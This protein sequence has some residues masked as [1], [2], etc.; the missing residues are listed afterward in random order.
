[1]KK[2]IIFPLIALALS[3]VLS[4]PDT[5]AQK[6][7]SA[8]VLLGA[9]L[10]QE[11]VEGNLEAA[12]ETYK[13]LLAEFPGNR[14]L[15]AQAQLHLGF[16]YEKLG[17]AQAKEARTAYERVVR[18]YADQAETVAQA[19]AR[20][21]ALA[22]L[23]RGAGSV[24][25]VTVR[26]AWAGPWYGG[27]G[28]PSRD[29]AYLTFRNESEDL[30]IRDLATGEIRQLTKHQNVQ[31]SAYQSVPSPDGKQVAYSWYEDG[32]WELRVVGLDGTAP[33]VLYSNTEVNAY[34]TDWSP[35]GKSILTVLDRKDRAH[36]IALVSSRDASVHPLKSS[37]ER[38]LARPRFS[39]D[40]RYIAYALQQ[41]PKSGEYDIFVLALEGGREIP[42][43]QHPAND[44]HPDWTPDGKRI[45]FF[46]NRTGT[47][48]AWWI[49]IAEGHPQGTPELVKPDLGLDLSPMGF[50]RNGSYYYGVH[51]EM[52]D[53]YIAELDLATGKLV[54]APS[55][56][57]QRFVGSNSKPDWSPDGL[58]LLFL[59]KRGAGY[60]GARAF[61]VRSTESGEVRELA[62]KLDR[63]PLA[64][65]LPDAR[66]L[67]VVASHPTDG[68]GPFRIDVQ[69]GDFV[70][71]PRP[72]GSFG[73]L[74][75]VSHDG[76]A[77]IYQGESTEPKKYC[78]MVRNLETS[79]N[80]EL[81]CFSD[82][83][84]FASRLTLSP[85]GSQLAFVM[86]ADTEGSMV[87]KVMPAAGGEARDLL[88]G[89]RI[90]FCEAP[91]AWAPDG[92]N[93]LFARQPNPPD[94]KTELWLISVQGGEPRRLE[95]A[96]EGMSDVCIHPDGRHIAFTEVKNRDEVWVLE[97]FL[98]APKAAK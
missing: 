49:Q 74:P 4:P 15:A 69:T 5:A 75:A 34:P 46:S 56:A 59:S 68:I 80:K 72:P 48:G 57:T 19:R 77:W 41:G 88:R 33:R 89:V 25:G 86:A 35:D 53:V 28:A 81:F 24:P 14:P 44:V 61:C 37:D 23:G 54:S 42:L 16:C 50:T 47:M 13:K 87:L 39:P 9:A 26:Q 38:G 60:W 62:S 96:A 10:H 45:L 3:I 6:S 2:S 95:L 11:E 64:R 82:P 79:K 20:L 91:I 1:M 84:H 36:Q 12:I 51:T 31:Q 90:P 98:P 67:L 58:Q 8:D 97:N 7:Q 27:M 63:V 70:A 43:V 66:S 17:E 55:A 22:A 92:Q 85:D 83:A 73:Y 30:A 29:G 78:V 32:L 65:W 76:K 94:R 18:D 21:A 71:V 40:G 93:L 52:S